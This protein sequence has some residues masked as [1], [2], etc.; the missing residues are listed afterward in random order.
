MEDST[1]CS[2]CEEYTGHTDLGHDRESNDMEERVK[3]LEQR[4]DRVLGVM[5]EWGIDEESEGEPFEPEF[6]EAVHENGAWRFARDL[7]AAIKEEVL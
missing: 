4:L 3:R 7:R 5:S 2:V 6:A 1:W